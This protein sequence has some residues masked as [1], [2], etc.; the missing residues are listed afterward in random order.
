MVWLVSR[1]SALEKALEKEC[2]FRV[3]VRLLMVMNGNS[4]A[5]VYTVN[6]NRDCPLF[7][8][9]KS[10]F[11]NFDGG[12]AVTVLARESVKKWVWE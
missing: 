6:C 4:N 11:N 10:G 9:F 8:L 2:P 7:V 1:A 5:G 3:T 12:C